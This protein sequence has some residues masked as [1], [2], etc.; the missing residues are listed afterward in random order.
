MLRF[1]E[2]VK[3]RV[4]IERISAFL[5]YVSLS[6]VPRF[7]LE[8]LSGRMKQKNLSVRGMLTRFLNFRD[9]L[10]LSRLSLAWMRDRQIMQPRASKKQRKH[11][12]FVRRVPE[13]ITC[14]IFNLT[15]WQHFLLE[16][17]IRVSGSRY[18]APRE[19]RRS[20]GGQA[21]YRGGLRKVIFLS[22][23]AYL[24]TR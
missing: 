2:Q 17:G 5:A 18:A 6:H 3:Q 14:C 11:V 8:C 23:R 16:G 1:G 22:L 10:I 19:S 4:V 15:A 20:G 9:K 24:K 21:V 13:T 12:I 7:S